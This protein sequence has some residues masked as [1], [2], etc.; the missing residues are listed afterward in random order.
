MKFFKKKTDVDD[1]V[2]DQEL[3][4]KKETFEKIVVDPFSLR[5]GHRSRIP[6]AKGCSSRGGIEYQLK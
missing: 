6:T 3:N 5:G 4:D 2:S 1:A